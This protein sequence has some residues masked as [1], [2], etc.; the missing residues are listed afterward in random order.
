MSLTTS[1]LFE[2]AISLSVL[3]SVTHMLNTL[4]HPE[5]EGT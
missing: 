1:V 3:G 2:T 4:G 5:E